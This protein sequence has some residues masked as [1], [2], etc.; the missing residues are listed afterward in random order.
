MRS[1]TWQLALLPN[2]R[3]LAAAILVRAVMDVLDGDPEL[4]RDARAFLTSPWCEDLCLF[5]EIDHRLLRDLARDPGRYA[6][7]IPARWDDAAG[8]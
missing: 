2:Y 4:R 8:T 1:F 6:G 5:C 3:R 7:R